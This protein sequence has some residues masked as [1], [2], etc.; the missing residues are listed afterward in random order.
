LCGEAL[1][2]RPAFARFLVRAWSDSISVSPDSFA[3]VKTHV[4]EAECDLD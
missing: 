3:E 1:S 2:R 4:A